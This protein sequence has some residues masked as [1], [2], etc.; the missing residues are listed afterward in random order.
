MWRIV[1]ERL[2]LLSVSGLY[3]V[4]VVAFFTIACSVELYGWGCVARWRSFSSAVLRLAP[5][6]LILALFLR[7]GTRILL[8]SCVIAVNFD[9][10]LVD[11]MA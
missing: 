7:R 10:L 8:I 2:A 6:F 9:C 3:V 4:G 11:M 5:L 1:P